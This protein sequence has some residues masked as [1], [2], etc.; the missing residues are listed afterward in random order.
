V[1]LA[2]SS[3]STIYRLILAGEFP[4]PVRMGARCTRWRAG[5]VTA[6]LQKVAEI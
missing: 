4:A 6:W 5:T 2:G 1:A 3:Q